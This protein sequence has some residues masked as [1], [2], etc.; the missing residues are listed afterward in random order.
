MEDEVE[1]VALREDVAEVEN[2][3]EVMTLAPN[4]VIVVGIVVGV[5]VGIGVG[6]GV[7]VGIREEDVVGVED[8]VGVAGAADVVWMVLEV[9][10]ITFT[11]FDVGQIVGDIAVDQTVDANLLLTL[12]IDVDL[13]VVDFAVEKI[14]VGVAVRLIVVDFAVDVRAVDVVVDLIVVEI[15]AGLI[16][17]DVTV[18][19]IEE[20]VAVG[21]PV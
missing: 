18:D 17:V 20:L 10:S 7:R 19:L 1:P 12:A 21:P 2:E 16:V 8:G 9:K 11:G 4:G 14:V 3:I 15:D 5:V 6:I 13:I